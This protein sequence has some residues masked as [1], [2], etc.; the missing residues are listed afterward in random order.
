[1]MRKKTVVRFKD[2]TMLKGV[3]VDFSPF[4]NH[5]KLE[6]VNGDVVTVDIDKIKAIFFVK[7]FEGDKK[8]EYKYDDELYWVGDKIIFQFNDGEKMVGYTQH[9]D[10]SPK[11]FFITPADLKGNNNYVFASR[12]AIES[13]SF[14]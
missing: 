1:M 8:Y 9:L 6:L 14:F 5:F 7:T 2:K 4:Y 3:I 12:T 11:G 13:M 10:F